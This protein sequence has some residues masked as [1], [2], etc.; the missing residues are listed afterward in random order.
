MWGE[1]CNCHI[2]DSLK[3]MPGATALYKGRHLRVDA[4]LL[5]NG[6]MDIKRPTMAIVR[7]EVYSTDPHLVK[8]GGKS[9][10]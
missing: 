8:K 4:S 10:L 7:G 2:E 1:G 6:C 9:I 5:G 3:G